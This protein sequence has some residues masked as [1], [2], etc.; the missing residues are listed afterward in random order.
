MGLPSEWTNFAPKPRELTGADK[1]NVFL[2]Y[3]SVSRTWVLNLY[4]VL[5]GGTGKEGD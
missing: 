5:I 2:S 1:W 4:D 3:R